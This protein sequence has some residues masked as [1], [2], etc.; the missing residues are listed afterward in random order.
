MI[1]ESRLSGQNKTANEISFYTLH[2]LFLCILKLFILWKGL[3]NKAKLYLEG[4]FM[5]GIFPIL[6]AVII[7]LS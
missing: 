2:H 4:L 3:Q 1:S 6:N 7:G 5:L